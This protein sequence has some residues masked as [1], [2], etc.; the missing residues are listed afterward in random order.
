[1]ERSVLI[2]APDI[3]AS[4]PMRLGQWLVAVGEPVSEGD[5]MVELIA[6]GVLWDVPSPAGGTLHDQSV[7]TGQ[8]VVV[9][10]RLG[11]IASP[12]A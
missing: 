3:G 2:V 11:A 8:A 6:D 1:M 12:A 10:E 4:G 7:R 5:R 9:G